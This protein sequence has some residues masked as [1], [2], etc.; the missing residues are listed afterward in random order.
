MKKQISPIIAF[1]II[2]LV[3]GIAGAAIFLFSQEVED[4]FLLEEEVVKKFTEEEIIEKN[5]FE[6]WKIYMSEE[7]GFEIKYPSN[8]NKKHSY[9]DI[10]FK[11]RDNYA[12]SV[13]IFIVDNPQNLDPEKFHKKECEVDHGPAE[14][15]DRIIFCREEGYKKGKNIEKGQN[16]FLQ[17]E[18]GTGPIPRTSSQ[19]SGNGF[20]YIIEREF[21][22]YPSYRGYHSPEYKI[23]YDKMLASFKLL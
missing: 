15:P 9:G 11:E 1:S 10:I 21:I 13:R 22:D 7:Y 14:S 16:N 19:I 3:A 12:D 17:Y 20:L 23:L 18:A 4:E 2:I 5:E 8:W 6:D